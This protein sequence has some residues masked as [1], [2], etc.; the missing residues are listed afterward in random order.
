M[1]KY[2][3]QEA[4][5]GLRQVILTPPPGGPGGGSPPGKKRKKEGMIG[6]KLQLIPGRDNYEGTPQQNLD[7][8]F[9]FYL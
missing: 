4:P 7:A 5:R 2:E 8:K 6:A 9:D 1:A 3:A